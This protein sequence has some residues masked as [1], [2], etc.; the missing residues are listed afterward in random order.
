MKISQLISLVWI[1]LVTAATVGSGGVASAAPPVVKTV[2][3][4]ATNP[5]IPHD[6]W[7]GKSITLK[8]TADVQGAAIQYTWDFGDGSPVA[9]GTVA[10]MYAIEAT[11]A[12]TGAVGT[13]FTTRLTVQDTV[14]GDTGSA[15]YFV[16]IQ[17][18]SLDVEVN[19]A[20]D[21]GLWYLHKT[22]RRFDIRGDWVSGG[23]ASSAYGGITATNINAFEVNGH[24]ESGSASNPYTETV[25]RGMRRLFEFLTTEPISVRTYPA[26]TGTVNPDSNGN[27]Y[28][29]RV[30]QSY[31]PY[32]GGM[33]VD[34]I[35][36][37]GMPTAV[38][39]TGQAPSGANPGIAGRTYADIVQDM[40]DSYAFGQYNAN[41]VARGGWRYDWNTGPDNSACQWAAI[42]LIPAEHEWGLTVPAWVKTENLD[43]WLAYTEDASGRFG[44]TAPTYFPYGPFALT[45]SGL[46]QLAMDGVG[47]G[48]LRWDTAENYMRST[49]C[50]GGGA[51]NAVRDYYY[52]LF[53][54]TKSMLLHDANGDGVPEP[55]TDLQ[56]GGASPCGLSPID[57][58]AAQSSAGDQCDGVARTLVNDQNAA[59]Y[60]YGHNYNSNQYPLETAQAI[61]MLNRTVF[62]SGLPVAVADAIPNPAVVGETITLDGSGSF[63]QDASKIIDSWEWDLDN[64]G[65]FD[66]SGPV[67]NTSFGALGDYPI[68]LRVTDDGVPELSDE[69]VLTI[70][71]TVPPIAPTADAD[72]PYILCPQAEPWFLDGSGSVNPDEGQSEIGQPGDTI[73]AY[74][75]DLDGDG[76]FD[77]AAGAQPDVTAYFLAAGVGDYLVQLKVT[78]TTGTSFPS[79]GFG[80]L[81]DTDSAQ[82]S[83][84]D[85]ADP[86]CASC[87]GDLTATPEGTGIRL[88]WTDIGAAAYH[89]FRSTTSGGPYV[90]LTSVAAMT[91]LDNDVVV[92]NTYYYVVRPAALNGAELCQSNE[93]TALVGPAEVTCDVDGDGDIDRMDLSLISRAR[94]QT[95]PPADP[96]Y[97]AN[98][99]GVITPADVK[100]CIPQ[101]TRPGCAIQ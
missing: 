91:Y 63:H 27:G 79:S 12:Y 74:Q 66:V 94:G 88:D 33:F 8:G 26:P 47:R 69:T 22:Q 97:D 15:L 16:Q 2:P 43:H 25:A 11:H 5:L 101:C 76:Q 36:A 62:A 64:D 92:G 59:G 100:A 34:A 50:N 90:F 46:V 52:G 57:W 40:V 71:V 17:S 39:T 65:V 3:W 95:V 73:Q 51:G 61:I 85:A 19:V 53:S 6:T 77:D 55:I 54:F 32:Q 75:W 18:Q 28:G 98:G 30:N 49:F 48:D 86:A 35:V 42:G 93:A 82:V 38:T 29:V 58:Y 81:S 24:L 4:V 78:D 45:P 9:T 72:G 44:Y 99:D 83:V 41:S 68:T 23:L 20:I 1:G 31:Y 84:K 7:S 56:C 14:S 70:R 87:V 89:V 60:W 96:S 37:S 10:N 21:E 67:V 80:D 13:I